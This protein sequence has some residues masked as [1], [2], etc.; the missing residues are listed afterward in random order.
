MSVIGAK[1]FFF[2]E[3][4]SLPADYTLCRP[5]YF[6]HV[7]FQLPSKGVTLLYGH[8]GPGSLIGAAV[9][10]S[11]N[12]GLGVCFADIKIDIGTWDANKQ[13]FE[14][15]NHCRFLNLPRRTNREVL[16]DINIHW[17]HWLNEEGAPA[18][19]FPRKPSNRMDLLDRLIELAPYNELNAIAYDAPTRFGISKFLTVFN[20]DA[21]RQ[22]ET[23]LIPPGPRL[24]FQTPADYSSPA[25]DYRT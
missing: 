2:Y 5:D 16:D 19:D 4:D 18:E 24:R 14:N 25:S 1:T 3:G 23:I 15:F 20:M 12:S 10:Q 8:K 9:R 7:D 22:D 17:N 21:I 13:K 6:Q 11:A